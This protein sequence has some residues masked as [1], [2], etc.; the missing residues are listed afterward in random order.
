MKWTNLNVHHQ[1][2]YQVSNLKLLLIH[3]IFIARRNFDNLTSNINHR[4]SFPTASPIN[5]SP[6]KRRDSEDLENTDR[7]CEG[8]LLVNQ[9]KPVDDPDIFVL[10][11]LTNI[12]QPHQLGGVRF[13]SVSYIY[14]LFSVIRFFSSATTI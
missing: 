14:T 3:G 12:L 1:H 9:G 11:H 6:R 7:T 2:Y 10:P 8:Q 5:K 13:L 4:L